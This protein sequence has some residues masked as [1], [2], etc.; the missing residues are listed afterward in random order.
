MINFINLNK[1]EPYLKL[2]DLYK[3]ALNKDQPIIEA[4]LI[5]S[6]CEEKKESDAR[7]V[8]LKII[9]NDEFIFFSN[10][11]SPKAK[12]FKRNNKISCVIF[13]SSI[14]T[15]IRLKGMIKKTSVSF[16]K[17]YFKKRSPEKNAL[18]IS[19]KQ[20]KIINNYEEII[21][22]YNSVLNKEN[23]I[24]C[25]K[26]WGGFS[27]KPYYFEFWEGHENR[28]NKRIVFERKSNDWKKYYLQP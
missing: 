12:Q 4:F 13:W 25:P 9:D 20:S 6:F 16:N 15:Q 1:N 18:A 2:F 22:N 3:N 11:E 21:E 26:H 19:S 23:L 8:N 7:Y 27:F 10:Y 24:D 17:E 14:Y 28:L 5:S